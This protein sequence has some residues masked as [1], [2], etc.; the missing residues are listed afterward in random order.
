MP[1]QTIDY[2]DLPAHLQ[3][4]IRAYI[5]DHQSV[6]GFLTAVLSNDLQGACSRADGV[7]RYRLWDIVR[8]LHNYAPEQCWGSPERV[9]EWLTP[10]KPDAA[11]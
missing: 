4:G 1:K 5:E 11:I 6:G 2:S 10:R 9:N 7:N 3:A 8:W